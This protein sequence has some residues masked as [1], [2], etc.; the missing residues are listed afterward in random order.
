MNNMQKKEELGLNRDQKP[1]TL[2]ERLII[3]CDPKL[4]SSQLLA[5]AAEAGITKA[6]FQNF[7]RFFVRGME[8]AHQKFPN[9][10]GPHD[11]VFGNVGHNIPPAV[12]KALFSTESETPKL[13]IPEIISLATV[14]RQRPGEQ[15]EVRHVVVVPFEKVKALMNWNNYRS[16]PTSFKAECRKVLRELG[17]LEYAFLGGVEEYYHAVQHQTPEIQ[18]ALALRQI[19]M[20]A[21]FA[22][23]P[24]RAQAMAPHDRSAAEI[25]VVPQ[26]QE[27]LKFCRDK[28]GKPGPGAGGRSR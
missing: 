24:A 5:Q 12:I 27:A 2:T 10:E 22:K 19:G 6:D 14:T 8:W 18:S 11:I 15:D 20:D 26:L 1:H 4:K 23:D 3:E 21:E 25:D 28:W 13:K 16:E 17:A 9:V 7:L